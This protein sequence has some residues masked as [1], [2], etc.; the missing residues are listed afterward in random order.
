MT[1]REQKKKQAPART[2]EEVVDAPATSETGENDAE[3][4]S[5]GIH[6]L[7]RYSRQIKSDN[8]QCCSK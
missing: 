2:E 3:R 6:D 1:E 8:E 4:D 5:R 7:S